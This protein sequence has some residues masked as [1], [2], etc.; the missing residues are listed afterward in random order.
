MQRN[1]LDTTLMRSSFRSFAFS[2]VNSSYDC[3]FDS[4][5]NQAIDESSGKMAQDDGSPTTR[6]SLSCGSIAILIFKCS[7]ISCYSGR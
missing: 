7:Q 6:V 3:Q 1:T 2:S 5:T 4:L